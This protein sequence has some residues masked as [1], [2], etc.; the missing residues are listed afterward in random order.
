[1]QVVL[2]EAKESY[3]PS[4]VHELQSDN[5]DDLDRNVNRIAAWLENWKQSNPN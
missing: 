5:L 3:D 4:I 1:M 2:E